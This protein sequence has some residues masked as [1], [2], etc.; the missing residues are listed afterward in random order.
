MFLI[1]V[2]RFLMSSTKF[3]I[4][5]KVW[6]CPVIALIVIRESLPSWHWNIWMAFLIA[7]VSHLL[8]KKNKTISNLVASCWWSFQYSLDRRIWSSHTY[9]NQVQRHLYATLSILPERKRFKTTN[10]NRTLMLELL[11]LLFNIIFTI[12]ISRIKI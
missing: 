3:L 12:E 8:Y 9:K 10:W 11:G 2:R 6:Q 4:R 7:S 5:F 1:Q